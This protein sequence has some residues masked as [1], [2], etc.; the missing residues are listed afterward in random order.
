MKIASTLIKPKS[1]ITNN[2]NPNN[3]F[4]VISTAIIPKIIK[5]V[6]QKAMKKYV[7]NTQCKN[8]S[9]NKLQQAVLN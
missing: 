4:H 7:K 1:I 6:I 5:I 2:P 9:L 8:R 3:L